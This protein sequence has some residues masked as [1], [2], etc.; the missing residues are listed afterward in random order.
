MMLHEDTVSGWRHRTAK[1]KVF[2]RAANDLAK[3]L[4]HSYLT[5]NKSTRSRPEFVVTAASSPACVD[6]TSEPSPRASESTATSTPT[7][8]RDAITIRPAV[9]AHLDPERLHLRDSGVVIPPDDCSTRDIS[10]DTLAVKEMSPPVSKSRYDSAIPLDA[11]DWTDTKASA[12]AVRS[13]D[14]HKGTARPRKRLYTSM[15]QVLLDREIESMA[16]ASAY[17]DG[18]GDNY[19][20]AKGYLYCLDIPA[21]IRLLSQSLGVNLSTGYCDESLDVLGLLAKVPSLRCAIL[22]LTLDFPPFLLDKGLPHPPPFGYSE[23]KSPVHSVAA[24]EGTPGHNDTAPSTSQKRKPT[25]R[26]SSRPEKQRRPPGNRKKDRDNDGDEEGNGAGDPGNNPPNPGDSFQGGDALR[27]AC[28][29]Y[30]HDP[31]AHRFC[32]LRQTLTAT[33]Y[34]KQHLDRYHLPPIH[35]PT[36]GEVFKKRSE[37]DEHIRDLGCERRDFSHPGMTL[38]QQEALKRTARNVTQE[39]RWYAIWDILFPGEPRPASP[40]VKDPFVEMV[41]VVMPRWVEQG[42]PERVGRAGITL[43]R[44]GQAGVSGQG[45][46]GEDTEAWRA[47]WTDVSSFTEG[48]VN[49]VAE[50]ETHVDEQQQAQAR[51]QAATDSSWD[52]VSGG[53]VSSQGQALAGAPGFVL[54]GTPA[55]PFS[56]T[57]AHAVAPA[58][59]QGTPSQPGFVPP[60]T[61]QVDPRMY[62]M[63]IPAGP[64]GGYGNVH[65][66]GGGAPRG[67]RPS[68]APGQM[69]GQPGMP[70]AVRNPHAWPGVSL[71][72]LFEESQG[73]APGYG[74]GAGLEA[75]F[76]VQAWQG[77]GQGMGHGMGQAPPMG[78]TTSYGSAL[79]QTLLGRGPEAAGGSF[80]GPG[81]AQAEMAGGQLQGGIRGHQDQA[82]IM[83]DAGQQLWPQGEQG[84]IDDGFE[85]LFDL[86]ADL[87]GS[88]YGGGV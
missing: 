8:T 59:A 23:I 13:L 62:D 85:Y 24:H 33:N 43:V 52:V 48:L 63:P 50:P 16:M 83:G 71:G 56:G 40:Y 19:W 1:L 77:M 60:G 49:G 82:P 14:R 79:D 3:Q 72:P 81:Q 2:L 21:V 46:A 84:Q 64:G 22:S 70:R 27:F 66:G 47:L 78:R 75:D 11:P 42:G 74:V 51:S 53:A 17:H 86:N 29:Y 30:K 45:G 55:L 32:L 44:A 68:L 41:E 58:L 26:Q 54:P 9:A 37:R 12:V 65:G 20:S 10:E 25:N 67:A 7:L 38:Q 28:P 5:P 88:G 18:F 36:C 87:G 76:P 31:I 61:T 80:G 69:Q 39:Q 4:I 73:F 35:C 6:S 57:A 34:V 15:L